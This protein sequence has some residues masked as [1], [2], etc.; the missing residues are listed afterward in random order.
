MCIDRNIVILYFIH[1]HIHDRESNSYWSFHYHVP[2][3]FL[4]FIIIIRRRNKT[5]K[6]H[7]TRYNAL[8]REL[9][10]SKF[11]SEKRIDVSLVY[12]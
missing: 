10:K 12:S 4:L 8:V 9:R 1:V 7:F 2:G 6:A 11:M 3:A 5:Y